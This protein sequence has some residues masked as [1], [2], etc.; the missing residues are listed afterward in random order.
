MTVAETEPK[1]DFEKMKE[2]FKALNF[3]DIRPIVLATVDTLRDAGVF[4]EE[5][6][7]LEKK[8]KE[9]YDLMVNM[10]VNPETVMMSFIE[11][12]P[13]DK[14][15]PLITLYLKISAVQTALKNVQTL[16]ADQK[17]TLGGQLKELANELTKLIE[18]LPQ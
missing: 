2:T 5:I 4:T 15:K 11:K 17:I 7:K 13:N 12:I 16:S 14:I 3:A 18:E 8:N 6:G 9:S 1:T 10:S